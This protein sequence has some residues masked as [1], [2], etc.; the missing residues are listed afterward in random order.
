MLLFETHYDNK[1][2]H[3]AWRGRETTEN[4]P[5]LRSDDSEP[6]EASE[7]NRQAIKS[8][9]A[10]LTD[11]PNKN[12]RPRAR[13]DVLWQFG[14][15]SDADATKAIRRGRRYRLREPQSSN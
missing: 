2:P 15:V 11:S 1:K 12:P 10:V 13:V 4:G 5:I 14:E 9:S 3:N 6:D 8:L 7:R